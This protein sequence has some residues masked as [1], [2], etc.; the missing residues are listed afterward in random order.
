M[1]HHVSVYNGVMIV[2]LDGRV[3]A[4]E[5]V[6]DIRTN[7]DHQ[8]SPVIVIVDFT[9]ASSFDQHLKSM[10]YRIL[11]HHYVSV[12]GMCGI[13][14]E[15]ANDLN[16]FLPVLRRVRKVVVNITEADLRADL[17]LTVGQP[18]KKL[19]GMLTY[20]KKGEQPQP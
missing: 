9:L 12:V 17:G 7:L 15:L 18:Q 8:S 5:V 19:G 2:R 6:Q 3:N 4:P 20:L 16:D 14:S 11:Q 10:F 1:A 13:N